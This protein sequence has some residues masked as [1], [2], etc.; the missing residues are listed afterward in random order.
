MLGGKRNDDIV[1]SS[2]NKSC[3]ALFGKVIRGEITMDEYRKEQHL[4]DAE[5]SSL[6]NAI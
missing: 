3:D 1:S 4:L 6:I 5:Y 2:Y